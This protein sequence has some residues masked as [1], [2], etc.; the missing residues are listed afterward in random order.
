MHRE[1]CRV[2]CQLMMEQVNREVEEK[3]QAIR[4]VHKFRAGLSAFLSL[5]INQSLNPAQS[6]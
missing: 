2:F 4:E 6:L 3:E 1:R 5:S